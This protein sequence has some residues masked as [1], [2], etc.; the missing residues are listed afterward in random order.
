MP[1]TGTFYAEGANPA[2][3][4]FGQFTATFVAPSNPTG[5]LFI[6]LYGESNPNLE[7]D[8]DNVALTETPDPPGTST[9]EPG[10]FFLAAGGLA[11]LFRAKRRHTA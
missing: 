1:G 11:L 9:P 7:I 5:D 2:P 8:Y 10:A 3:G 4:T 6:D